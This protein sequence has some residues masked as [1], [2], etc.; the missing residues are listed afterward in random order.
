M[1]NIS[2]IENING[3]LIEIS[4]FE[5]KVTYKDIF[6]NLDDILKLDLLQ[7]SEYYMTLLSSHRYFEFETT[8]NFYIDCFEDVCDMDVDIEFFIN[9]ND[10]NNRIG[11][12]VYMKN[13]GLGIMLQSFEI[14][15]FDID[16]E[17]VLVNYIF[18]TIFYIHLFVRHF[19]YDSLFMYLYHPVD[20]DDLIAIRNRRI[21]LFGNSDMECSVCLN[22][23]ILKTS[24]KHYLCQSCFSQLD[25]KICPLCRN[26]LSSTE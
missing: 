24:C 4:G 9:K 13:T 17:N 5:T 2:F 11:F 15:N 18:N 7:E 8:I 19:K 23:C 12:N 20:L 25:N 21:R 10:Q 3:F 6:D 14:T 26:N 22:K 16:D 1:E